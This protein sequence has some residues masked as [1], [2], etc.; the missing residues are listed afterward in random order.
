MIKSKEEKIEGTEVL[1]SNSKLG[2]MI[3]ALVDLYEKNKSF[4]YGE[5]YR[6]VLPND[7]KQNNN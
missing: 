2:T 6:R 5:I 4:T 1:V 7:K 3:L